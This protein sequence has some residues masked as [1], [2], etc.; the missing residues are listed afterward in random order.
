MAKKKKEYYWIARNSDTYRVYRASETERYDFYK[1]EFVTS[2]LCEDMFKRFFG[3]KHIRA[4]SQKLFYVNLPILK[5]V[6]IPKKKDENNRADF[7][8]F[9]IKDFKKFIAKHPFIYE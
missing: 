8:Q 6:K 7:F 5:E 4:W 1:A 3:I 2:M 9:T